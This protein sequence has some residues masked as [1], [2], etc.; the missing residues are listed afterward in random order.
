[1]RLVVFPLAL[2]DVAVGMYQ[3]AEAI[4]LVVLP[5]A[6]IE[7][8]ICPDLPTSAIALLSFSMPL[9]LVLGTVLKQKFFLFHSLLLVFH[10]M[11]VYEVTKLPPDLLH[12]LILVVA[13]AICHGL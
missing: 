5:E 3:A 2:V 11:G 12:L 13:L 9:T 10:W 7:R 1:M 6:L 8:A 4:G